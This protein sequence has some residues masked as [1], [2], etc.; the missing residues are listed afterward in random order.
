ML[1]LLP[2]VLILLLAAA[3]APDLFAEACP[4]HYAVCEAWTNASAFPA[5]SMHGVAGI[6]WAAPAECRLVGIP[7]HYVPGAS[8][9]FA[10]ASDAIVSRK[11][12]AS[13][14][15]FTASSRSGEPAA[16]RDGHDHDHAVH[17]HRSRVL[18]D[19]DA[20]CFDCPVPSHGSVLFD[21]TAPANSQQGTVTF[22]A[23]CG[24]SAIGMGATGWVK[25]A[26]H[27]TMEESLTD[28][29]SHSCSGS[30]TYTALA[31][32]KASGLGG[33]GNDMASMNHGGGHGSMAFSRFSEGAGLTI[34]FSD[35]TAE[36]DG[37]HAGYCVLFVLIGM[38]VRMCRVPLGAAVTVYGQSP[39]LVGPSTLAVACIF[40]VTQS[41][42]YLV[43]LA[44][45]TMDI[46]L[47]FC[48]MLGLTLGF[49][50]ETVLAKR[51]RSLQS[52]NGASVTDKAGARG[53]LGEQQ[54][55]T[56]VE[57]VRMNEGLATTLDNDAADCCSVGSEVHT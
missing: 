35:W 2:L 37:Q 47:F 27:V 45:M 6:Q 32:F 28:T 36:T 55:A 12:F 23:L 1:A 50:A 44:S 17:G 15:T 54:N 22:A 20:F 5:A 3:P 42:A 38:V 14:G 49:V 34:L 8:Y 7:S 19:T 16:G 41:L 13:Q 30:L 43:M 46:S 51:K 57:V 53:G 18:V 11:L 39:K 29:T 52:R 21:W 33:A 26:A 24:G 10:V 25:T 40:F 9:T 31:E 56:T 48:I 4:S